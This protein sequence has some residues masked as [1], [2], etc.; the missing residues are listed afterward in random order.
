M[1]SQNSIKNLLAKIIKMWHDQEEWVGCWQSCFFLD[2][3]KKL[4]TVYNPSDSF[5]LI[6]SQMVVKLI[7]ASYM[8]RFNQFYFLKLGGKW[9][10]SI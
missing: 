4:K 7:I 10:Y 1:Y 8:Y 6:M 2:I 9:K 3:G 5:P